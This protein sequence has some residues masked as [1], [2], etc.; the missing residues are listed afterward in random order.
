M[1]LLGGAVIACTLVLWGATLTNLVT[2]HDSDPAGNAL[3]QAFGAVML[4]G[5]WV[6]LAVVLVGVGWRGGMPPWVK[7]CALILH[8]ASLAASLAL[9]LIHI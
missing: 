6:L 5:L 3:S 9:S 1:S 4:L 7:V 2:L 8:P